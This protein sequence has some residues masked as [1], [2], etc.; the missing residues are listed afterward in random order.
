MDP[1]TGKVTQYPIPVVKPGWSLGTLSIR[2]D[3]NDN[4]WV[5]VMYQSA[6]AKFD[7]KTE[8]FQVFPLPPEHNKDWTQVNMVRPGIFQRGRQGLAAGQR[9]RHDLSA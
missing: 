7:K 5:G 2:V 4:P 3:R 1:K 8:K 9:H 6:I